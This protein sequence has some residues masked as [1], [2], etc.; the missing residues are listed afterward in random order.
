M[1]KDQLQ[2]ITN[3]T[4]YLDCWMTGKK[5]K[6]MLAENQNSKK[7]FIVNFSWTEFRI[8]ISG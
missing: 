2:L 5:L 3:A 4:V 8:C 1:N 7:L 6:E